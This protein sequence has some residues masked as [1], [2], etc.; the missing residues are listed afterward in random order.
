MPSVYRFSPESMTRLARQW[1]E[2]IER[3]RSHPCV[4][5]WVPFNE[6]WGV[7]DLPRVPEQRHAVQA[8]YHLTKTLD[9]T[10]PVIGND[11]W[12]A[13]ATDIIGIHDYDAD[14]ARLA[15]RYAS[16]DG[17]I[18]R[19]LRHE[20]PGSRLLV[21]EGFDYGGQ[22]IMLTEFGGIAYSKDSNGTWGYSRA[23]TP[24]D[25][26]ARY[27]D[28]LAAVRSVQMFAGFCYT[29][30]TDTY[31]EANGLLYMDRTPKFAAEEIACATRGPRSREDHAMFERW[32]ERLMS[33]Q[34]G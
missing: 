28:L 27:F 13:A 14:P 20:R 24:D 5:A 7:P 29:Q 12:E 22:P 16:G 25:L 23:R 33:L 31:Q 32:K 1:T 15:R 30:F 11:G 18:D 19:V 21:L 3:D 6:S 2:A 34:R 17:A 4:I 26:A 8:M 9:P 10:R